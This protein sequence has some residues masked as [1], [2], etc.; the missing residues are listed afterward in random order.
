[1]N[2]VKRLLL[3]GLALL[4]LYMAGRTLKKNSEVI[5]LL[6]LL[7]SMTANLN[8]ANTPKTRALEDRINALVPAV[9]TVT[10]T[11][12]AAQATASAAL[13]LAGGTV[14]GSVQV[15]GNHSVGGALAVSGSSS[16]SNNV[17]VGNQVNANNFAASGASSSYGFTSHG[18]I[19]ADSNITAGGS[20]TTADLYVSGQRVAP[21]QGTPGGYPVTGTPSNAGL[22]TLCNEI[23]QGLQAAGIFS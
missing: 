22:G 23:I 16:F 14:T 2:T 11:A 7:V 13:P 1:V 18:N 21:G 3:L 8:T 20:V 19:A 10:A 4:A 17:T 12:N 9:G 5:G 15:N 6:W